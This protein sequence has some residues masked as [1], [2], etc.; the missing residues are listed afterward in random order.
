MI[1][2]QELNILSICHQQVFKKKQI[3]IHHTVSNGNPINVCSWWEQREMMTNEKVGTAYV[4]AGRKTS[5]T[6][7]YDDG[8]IYSP[9]PDKYWAAHLGAITRPAG[10]KALSASELHKHSIGIELCNWGWL[11]EDD[12]KYYSDKGKTIPPDEVIALD[13]RGKQYYQLYTDAQIE[14]LRLLLLHLTDKYD[15]PRHFYPMFGICPEALQ[16]TPGIFSHTS[17]RTDKRD[18]APQPKL[19]AMLQS[20]G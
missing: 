4:I 9:F 15:I 7:K 17:V 2:P 11:S 3:Y 18:C 10:I 1:K 5:A 13:Y 20:L 14:S 6:V 12:G 8:A 16:G 19:L